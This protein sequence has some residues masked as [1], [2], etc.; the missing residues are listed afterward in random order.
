MKNGAFIL[1][2]LAIFSFVI[3]VIYRLYLEKEINNKEINSN[4]LE[5]LEAL[6]FSYYFIAIILA[7]LAGIT[8]WAK[9]Y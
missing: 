1:L 5:R 3:G 9:F 6:E 7:V 4:K 8:M 2:G